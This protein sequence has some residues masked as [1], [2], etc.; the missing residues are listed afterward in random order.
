MLT[1]CSLSRIWEAEMVTY[2]NPEE[3]LH[4]H[5][6]VLQSPM[7]S[8]ARSW[9]GQNENIDKKVNVLSYNFT[10]T[11]YLRTQIMYDFV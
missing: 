9:S 4:R 5:R 11:L 2:T 1:V 6:K 7:S 10:Y 8:Q 3:S